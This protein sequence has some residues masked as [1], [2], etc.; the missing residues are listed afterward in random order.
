MNC[1]NR[2]THP[3]IP[4]QRPAIDWIAGGIAGFIM[5]ALLAY[6]I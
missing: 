2:H 4:R 3:R 5:G 6:W 1:V